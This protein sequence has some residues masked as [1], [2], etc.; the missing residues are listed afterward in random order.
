MWSVLVSRVCTF[1]M[2]WCRLFNQAVLLF[3]AVL[4][5]STGLSA[6]EATIVGTVTDPTG[7]LVPRVTITIANTQTGAVRTSVTNNL[8]QYVASGLPIGTYDLSAESAGFGL[9]MSRGIIL[10]VNARVRID[11]QL[12]IGAE[13]ENVVVESIPVAVQ[14][15]SGEQSSLVSGTQN[16]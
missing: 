5:L 8:G 6:Q 7:G 16:L 11:F 9:G 3:A 15:D 12:K 13:K 1:L 2:P 14:A 4:V 10:N